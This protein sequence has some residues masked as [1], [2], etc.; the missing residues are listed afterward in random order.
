MVRQPINCMNEDRS[1]NGSG[2]KVGTGSTTNT[3]NPSF[4]ERV[5]QLFFGKPR[6]RENLINQLKDAHEHGVVDA[7][8]LAMAEG[9][10]EMGEMQ[11][12]DVM[13]PRSQ[14]VT[15]SKDCIVSEALPDIIESGHSRFPVVG[16]DKDEVVGILLAKDLLSCFVNNAVDKPL[17]ELVRPAAIV[18]ESKRL[19][20]L[21][22]DFRSSRYHMAIVV[23]EYG[24]VSGLATIED[25]LEEIVGEID[26][27]TDNEEEIADIQKIKEGEFRVQALTTIEDFNDAFSS[28]FSDEEYDTIGGIIVSEFGRVPEQSEQIDL[29]GFTFAVSKTDQ[30]RIHEL[31]VTTPE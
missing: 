14:I 6:N 18:P 20:V 19:N 10:L 22:R 13:I 31:L 7:D 5:S 17:S 24:G 27:E 3:G 25:V 26:D 16:E 8:V 11:V 21:L 29:S 30:R 15:L 9:A 28:E 23:D 12:R 4:V 1:S 2:P